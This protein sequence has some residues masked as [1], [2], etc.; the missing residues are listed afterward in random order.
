[1]KYFAFLKSVMNIFLPILVIIFISPFK[2][3]L[4]KHCAPE[5]ILVFCYVHKNGIFILGGCS[6][7][8]G[9]PQKNNEYLG[10]YTWPP[11]K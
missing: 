2:L 11:P 6:F 1:M 10:E 4:N 9:V 3:V 5:K 7:I 8:A